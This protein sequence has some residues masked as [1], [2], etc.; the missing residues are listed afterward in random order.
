[1]TN[2]TNFTSTST[3][4]PKSETH[5][6]SAIHWV[7]IVQYILVFV[8][9]VLG[10]GLVVGITAFGMKRSVN[11]IWI[12]NLAVAD[13]LCCLSV[14]FS[15]MY[16][17]LGYWPLDLFSCKFFPS[18]LLIS[19]YASV[20]LLTMISIDRCA[21]VI[22]PVWCQNHRSLG[23]AYVACAV[24]WILAIV[25]NSPSFIFETG[26]FNGTELCVHKYSMT[27]LEH[28]YSVLK[29]ITTLRLLVGFIVPFLVIVT[30]YSILAYRVR[31]RFTQNTKMMKVVLAVIIGFFVC[32]LPYH[33]AGMIIAF[34]VENQKSELLQTTS[35]LDVIFIAMAFMNSC[36]NPI[37]YMLMGQ[38]FKSKFK[39]SLRL[40]LKNI[41]VE[42]MSQSPYSRT[43]M[44]VSE[45]KT[46]ESSV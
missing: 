1:M 15:I 43:Y 40:I 17:A 30:C 2:D 19:M 38:D 26:N 46:A 25:L 14:P 34:H 32:W 11:A 4:Y 21:L 16:T 42:E 41:L 9:G 18:I 3:I 27:T 31:Q 13:L 39:T 22:K 28:G 6:L 37:I 8:L 10:N 45:S 33:V 20:F 5:Q 36:I 24:M 12:L 23:K 7:A 29:S 44:P 35:D